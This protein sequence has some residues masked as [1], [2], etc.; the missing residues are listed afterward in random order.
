MRTYVTAVEAPR[1]KGAKCVT[2]YG[3]SPVQVIKIIEDAVRKAKKA[4]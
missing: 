2:V 1:K 4:G 3:L